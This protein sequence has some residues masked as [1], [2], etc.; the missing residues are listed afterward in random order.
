MTD[1]EKLDK[2]FGEIYKVIGSFRATAYWSAEPLPFAKRKEGKRLKFGERSELLPG[3]R[4]GKGWD[5][6]WI[7]LTG[8]LPDNED[9]DLALLM[10]VGGEACLYDEAG[11]AIKGFT[12]LQSEFTVALGKPGKVCLFLP[13]GKGRKVT[14]WADCGANDLFGAK[15][16]NGVFVRA[17][18]ARCDLEKR[19][20]FYDL[21][22]LLSLAET[23]NGEARELFAEAIAKKDDPREAREILRPFFER[24]TEK[25]GGDVFVIGNAHIDLAWLWPM[26]ETRRKAVRTLATVCNLMN[27]YPFY[28]FSVSQP[29]MLVWVKEDAPELYGRVKKLISEG[30]VE[31][32]GGMW[33]EPDTNLPGGESLV[34]QM[35]Y[36]IE[37][38]EKEFGEKQTVLCL[39]D[40][41]GFCG[42]LPQLIQK[43]GMNGYLTT[44]L[45]WN[46]VNQFPH[47]SFLWRGIDGTEVVSHIPPEG[48]YNSGAW[49]H[50]VKRAKGDGDEPSALLY[51]IGDGG[52]GPGMEHLE[53]LSRE[54]HLPGLPAV[55]NGSVREFFAELHKYA[56]SLPIW[57]G[58]LYLEKHQGVYT[59]FGK[60]KTAMADCEA[61]LYRAEL[62][63]ALALRTQNW[64]DAEKKEYK[65]EV[66]TLW[67]AVLLMQFHD[68]LPGSCMPRAM[69]E[70]LAECQRL[71]GE[72]G[73]L[74][75]RLLAGLVKPGE[76]ACIWNVKPYGEDALT[77]GIN[78]KEPAGEPTEQGKNFLR[79]EYLYIEFTENGEIGQISDR[80]TGE[81]FLR[82]PAEL[83]F[84][85]DHENAWEIEKGKRVVC[86]MHD[87][88]TDGDT[89]RFKMIYG[90]YSCECAVKLERGA[91]RAEFLFTAERFPVHTLATWAFPL[92]HRNVMGRC[93]IQFGEIARP[94]TANHSHDSAMKE[95]CF[96]EFVDISDDQCGLSLLSADRHGASLRD[97]V[98]ELSLLRTPD[99]PAFTDPNGTVSAF[100][101]FPHGAGDDLRA[102]A[103][104][105]CNPAVCAIGEPVLTGRLFDVS[106]LCVS[107]VKPAED[108]DGL[109][110]RAFNPKNAFVRAEIKCHA[111]LGLREMS[112]TDLREQPLA[113]GA[114]EKATLCG[115]VLSVPPFGIVTV[116]M[117]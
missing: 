29:Q 106:P 1:R 60:L 114:Q 19:G 31:V 10:D 15:P 18:F 33:V 39:P 69:E 99:Y 116:R 55:R 61:G 40:S 76:Q 117:K 30:R 62:F 88:R 57:D 26:R 77:V 6:A 82:A 90:T 25:N 51:G 48:N 27:K 46:G 81:T 110:L 45:S 68:I 52:G 20:L 113:D 35:L 64:G 104:D 63:A 66:E 17:D 42:Q 58:E 111:A 75:K 102:E 107:A 41:F 112:L 54:A 14:F 101:L 103:A 93:G 16:E 79:N 74:E 108:G 87:L 109:I 11:N 91:R 38:S 7:E 89:R 94:T 72:I 115:N 70:S 32:L 28:R 84:Y 65:T 105:Y 100:A 83:R 2:L 86:Q 85:E 71:A 67:K 98:L 43:A 59:T 9:G 92:K 50:S 13:T 47:K 53:R 36:G 96:R 56:D 44:K 80:K 4:W 78:K 97:C 49:P 8:E 23:G 24:E 37:E 34:R 12:N 22:V 73:K 3:D 95:V 5:C 21:D